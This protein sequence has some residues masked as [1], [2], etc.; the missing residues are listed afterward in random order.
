LAART[1]I[2]LSRLEVRE[3]RQTD[4]ALVVHFSCGDDEEDRDLDEFLKADA[5]RLDGLSVVRVFL[6]LY[7][8]SLCG[9]VAL[10]ADCV[11]LKSTEKKVLALAHDDHPVIPA[12]K[13]ARLA[14]TRDFREKHRGL[15]EALVAFAFS[16]AMDASRHIG[17]RLLTLDAYTKSIAFYEKLGFVRNRD[18]EHTA[19]EHPS[20]RFDIHTDTPPPWL[21]KIA[22]GA[23]A[24]PSASGSESNT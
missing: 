12:L 14:V 19:K 20:M 17:C 6:A 7:D 2:D 4:P 9:Y 13:I 3:I 18:K 24:T 23:S 5:F 1:P 10:L 16:V 15:G 22:G 8:G 21:L 11:R